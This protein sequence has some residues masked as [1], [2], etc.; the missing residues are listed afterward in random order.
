MSRGERR[1]RC[2]SPSSCGKAAA[3]GEERGSYSCKKCELD[4]PS[5][6]RANAD[7]MRLSLPALYNSHNPLG[8]HIIVT[9]EAS[10]LGRI[11]P[12]PLIPLCCA[13]CL[14]AYRLAATPPRPRMINITPYDNRNT[15]PG[16]QIWPGCTQMSMRRCR[17]RIGTTTQ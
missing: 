15:R 6:A 10:C 8:L 11:R 5:H 13:R 7:R 17:G 9:V 2:C 14:R 12:Q 4:L 1:A 3:R 16:P